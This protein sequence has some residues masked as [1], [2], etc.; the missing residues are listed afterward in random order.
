MCNSSRSRSWDSRSNEGSGYVAI[1]SRRR[2]SRDPSGA[3]EAYRQCQTFA[4]VILSGSGTSGKALARS[5]INSRCMAER[6]VDDSAR[7]AVYAQGALL[8]GWEGLPDH[9]AAP[10]RR[11]ARPRVLSSSPSPP[12]FESPPPNSDPSPPSPERLPRPPPPHLPDSPLSACL[13]CESFAF[14]GRAAIRSGVGDLGNEGGRDPGG[15]GAPSP[16]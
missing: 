14:H 7:E 16:G 8:A 5:L 2:L 6:Y 9:F 11:W 12:A 4:E 15:D 10:P 3:S 13:P 1:S